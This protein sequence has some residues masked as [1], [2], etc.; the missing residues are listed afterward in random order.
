MVFA[1]SILREDETTHTATDSLSLAFVS[2]REV[3]EFWKRQNSIL[4]FEILHILHIKKVNKKVL[5]KQAL[6]KA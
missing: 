3:E 5:N 4:D 6:L 1:S 2:E